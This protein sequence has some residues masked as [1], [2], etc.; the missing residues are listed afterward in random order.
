[1]KIIANTVFRLK[2][3]KR[4]F[5][6]KCGN[7]RKRQKMI[8][9]FGQYISSISLELEPI[10]CSSVQSLIRGRNTLKIIIEKC[11]QT[12]KELTIS[13]TYDLALDTPFQCLE[14]LKLRSDNLTANMHASWFQ[15][16]RWFPSLRILL[17]DDV[18]ENAQIDDTIVGHIPK[19]EELCLFVRPNALTVRPLAQFINLNRH[20]SKLKIW[21]DNVLSDRIDLLDW[22]I[23][24]LLNLAIKWEFL[25]VTDLDIELGLPP[26]VIL[27]EN[28]AKLDKLKYL[29][30][31]VDSHPTAVE[32]NLSLTELFITTANRNGS[33]CIDFICRHPF[34][35]KL[36]IK[37]YHTALLNN[38]KPIAYNLKDLNELTIYVDGFK[39]TDATHYP[40]VLFEFVRHC[41]ALRAMNIIHVPRASIPRDT[42]KSIK[43]YKKVELKIGQLYK[44]NEWKLYHKPKVWAQRFRL[45]TDKSLKRERFASQHFNF[46]NEF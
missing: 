31:N 35:K 36:T 46:V 25:N 21:I 30:F 32:Y 26:S 39:R 19:L 4:T 44:I 12:L 8:K 6:I 29:K 40:N 15:Y 42:K 45:Q 13:E 1:M 9:H 43:L 34:L 16:S 23:V 33:D 38:L 5:V 27:M 7:E 2:H 14:T 17:I 10:D 22:L 37:T 11:S 3:G 24:Y 18:R 20:I 41:K 28:V